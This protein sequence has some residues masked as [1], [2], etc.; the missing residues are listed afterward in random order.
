MIHRVESGVGIR[1]AG[2][3]QR[4]HADER[5]RT[6]SLSST[7]QCTGLGVS[8]VAA[9][10]MDDE[11]DESPDPHGR[12]RRVGDRGGQGNGMVTQSGAVAREGG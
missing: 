2:Q 12:C 1:G 7:T 4:N 8:I 5:R 6:E 9:Q 10:A 3:A 11:D